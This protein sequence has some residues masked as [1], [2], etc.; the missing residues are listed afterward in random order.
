[1]SRWLWRC[2]RPPW[3]RRNALVCPTLEAKWTARCPQGRKRNRD[4]TCK[5]NK[6]IFVSIGYSLRIPS[7]RILIKKISIECSNILIN[8]WNTSN[9]DFFTKIIN[10]NAKWPKFISLKVKAKQSSKP[11]SKLGQKTGCCHA[12]LWKFNGC[13][14]ELCEK[15][16]KHI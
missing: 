2:I 10:R 13:F 11:R 9:K 7:S 16:S 5:I 15:I 3:H 8:Y 12:E 14:R 4:K 6:N 1:M